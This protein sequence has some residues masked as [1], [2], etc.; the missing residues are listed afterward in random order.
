MSDTEGV[1]V[2]PAATIPKV[3]P[4]LAQGPRHMVCP[5]GGPIRHSW[6]KTKF[7]YLVASLSPEAATEVRDLILVPPTDAPYT[8]HSSSGS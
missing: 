2:A 5:S 4:F 6:Q 8:Q 7:D 1:S 3:A